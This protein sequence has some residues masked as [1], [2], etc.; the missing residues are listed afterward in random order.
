MNR[1]PIC[2]PRRISVRL[3]ELEQLMLR[4]VNE[5]HAAAPAAI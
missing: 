4:D 3:A 2:I 5:R 1:F